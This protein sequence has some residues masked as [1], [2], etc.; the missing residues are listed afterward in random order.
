MRTERPATARAVKSQQSSETALSRRDLLQT[1][2]LSA[3]GLMLFGS[4][5]LLRPTVAGAA[6]AI[7][8]SYAGGGPVALELDGSQ[9]YVN[10]VEGGNAVAT[11]VVETASPG[12]SPGKHIGGVSYEDIVLQLPFTV[13]PQLASWIGDTVTKGPV[14]KSGAISYLDLNRSEWK[15]LEFTDALISEIAL[16]ACD[17][18][19]K[20]TVSLKLRLT[21]EVTRWVGG[22]GKPAALPPPSRISVASQ[23]NFRLN[24]QGLEPACPYISKIDVLT[25]KLPQ[26]ASPAGQTR[27]Y[28]KQAAV[29]DVSP[30]K[31]TVAEA[32]AGLFYTW[33]DN[34][35]I[36][37]NTAAA[38]AE[39]GGV[40]QLLGTD[41]VTVLATVQLRNLGITRYAPELYMSG[42]D[43]IG[44]V[45]V[46]M[47]CEGL[48]LK[49][50]S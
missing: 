29:P 42:V 37:G 8:R 47:Y 16:P 32:N 14:R 45:D 40:L 21:P 17:A 34:V 5:E 27:D 43:A 30:L 20:N 26:T 7:G 19:L 36:R 13:A 24:I 28:L 18:S 41:M 39:R 25:W 46:D 50:G 6:A 22:S 33:L 15:R 49:L 31:I 1:L 2:G 3:G 4:A 11:V 9:S 12:M 44:R 35:V 48:S 23:S 10:S 38:D